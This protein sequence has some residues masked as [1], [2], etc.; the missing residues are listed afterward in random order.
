M[1]LAFHLIVFVDI[2][3]ESHNYFC[4]IEV[5]R[6]DTQREISPKY[7]DPT[8]LPASFSSLFWYTEFCLLDVAIR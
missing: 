3:S 7:A 1:Q 6:T 4:D 5:V 8:I 2:N